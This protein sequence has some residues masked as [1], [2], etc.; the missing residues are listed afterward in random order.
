MKTKKPKP[1]S[2]RDV[3]TIAMVAGGEKLIRAHYE[4][5]RTRYQ[6]EF[7]AL[8]KPTTRK[9]LRTVVVEEEIE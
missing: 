8:P 2:F 9:V 4:L 5:F 7:D 6:A 1:V 3:S